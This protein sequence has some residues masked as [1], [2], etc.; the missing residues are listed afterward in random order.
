M[1]LAG[2]VKARVEA[3]DGDGP[4]AAARAEA[5]GAHD[6]DLIERHGGG[7]PMCCKI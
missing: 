3:S 2:A 1:A 6:S 7:R 5:N 4:A